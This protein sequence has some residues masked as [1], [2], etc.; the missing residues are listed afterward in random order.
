M[1]DHA[2][3]VVKSKQNLEQ[4]FA[5]KESEYLSNHKELQR[6]YE[7]E[8]DALRKRAEK[9]E[10]QCSELQSAVDQ[11]NDQME[12]C[13]TL[14][15]TV[16]V[17]GRQ[18]LSEMEEQRQQHEE[19]LASPEFHVSAIENNDAEGSSRAQKMSVFS[20]VF[21]KIDADHNGEVNVKE[22]SYA[23]K[24]DHEA[25]EILHLP[26]NVNGSDGSKKSTFHVLDEIERSGCETLTW[27]EFQTNVLGSAYRHHFHGTSTVRARSSSPKKG[28]RINSRPLD[29]VY[30]AETKRADSS[31]FEDL[32]IALHDEISHE[33][34][35][36][37]VYL[38]QTIK[39]ELE[40]LRELNGKMKAL[41]KEK[42]YFQSRADEL[43]RVQQSAEYHAQRA[44][45]LDAGH[46]DL[47]A[48]EQKLKSELSAARVKIQTVTEK[49]DAL[50]SKLH[51][52][53]H[54]Q[55]GVE[56]ALKEAHEESLIMESK[57]K[58]AKVN[59]DAT[60]LHLEHSNRELEQL[61]QERDRTIQELDGRAK[62]YAEATAGFEMYKEKT[63]DEFV[64]LQRDLNRSRSEHKALL[65]DH[66]HALKSNAETLSKFSRAKKELESV[67]N[68]FVKLRTEH[69]LARRELDEHKT[70]NTMLKKGMTTLKQNQANVL[71]D[72][73][74]VEERHQQHKKAWESKYTDMEQTLSRTLS[75]KQKETA[76]KVA[77]ESSI[78]RDRT[79]HKKIL[80]DLK[81]AKSITHSP[82]RLS[83]K[84]L[85]SVGIVDKVDRL[86]EGESMSMNLTKEVEKSLHEIDRSLLTF[87]SE[88]QAAEVELKRVHD[89]LNHSGQDYDN[90]KKNEP[91]TP[92]KYRTY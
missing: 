18:H 44:E 65:D 76:E 71:K 92:G 45:Q 49:H 75:E 23:L 5:E 37:H 40:L 82:L 12:R 2:S 34:S 64:N 19:A 24:R 42:Q 21:N 9:A 52:T 31:T 6:D 68:A 41:Q 27:H 79:L 74:A 33:R 84:D 26:V 14:L 15:R 62:A 48:R 36:T 67:G 43:S 61:G 55:E 57:W 59:L 58:E 83:T 13:G 86:L 46:R 3:G 70:N 50:A 81:M 69:H 80:D 4:S 39:D 72:L 47:S 77:L 51:R 87:V 60:V 25:N 66:S 89:L 17:E 10:L 7:S 73:V 56:E 38:S 85:Q 54:Y 22:L 78:R 63:S 88:E 30:H 11:I 32:C 35:V 28:S 20:R 53:I 90:D 16:K 91:F 8:A 29:L 1:G